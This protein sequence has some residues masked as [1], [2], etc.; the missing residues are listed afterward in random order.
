MPISMKSK[1]ATRRSRSTAGRPEPPGDDCVAVWPLPFVFAAFAPEVSVFDWLVEP[2]EPPPTTAVG[3]LPFEAANWPAAESAPAA[4][5]LSAACVAAWI[6]ADAH[7]QPTPESAC[8]EFC[9]AVF[10]FVAEAVDCAELVWLTDP[11]LPGLSTRTDVLSFD[12]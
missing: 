12:G 5:P 6:G 2:P 11:S 4:C 7:P 1:D 8:V 9:V 3:A 10:A